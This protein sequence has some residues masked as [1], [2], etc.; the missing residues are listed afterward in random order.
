MAM[1][2]Y[3]HGRPGFVVDHIVPL[4]RGGDDVPGNMQGAGSRGSEGKRPVGMS[5]NP[6]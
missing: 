1:T 6:G 4:K 3:P 2:G 5:E